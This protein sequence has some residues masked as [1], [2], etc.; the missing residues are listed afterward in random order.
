MQISTAL[1]ELLNTCILQVFHCTHTGAL[2]GWDMLVLVRLKPG[3]C[4]GRRKSGQR[5][6]RKGE[7]SKRGRQQAALLKETFSLGLCKSLLLCLL[8]SE[9]KTDHQKY[10]PVSNSLTTHLSE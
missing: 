9:A 2:Y 7:G 8:N 4:Y 10:C 6:G 5:A 3:K 1:G